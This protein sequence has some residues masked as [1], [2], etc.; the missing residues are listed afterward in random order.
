MAVDL[1]F[2]ESEIGLTGEKQEHFDIFIRTE[3]GEIINFPY[4]G[5]LASD[6]ME[7]QKKSR[8]QQTLQYVLAVARTQELDFTGDLVIEVENGKNIMRGKNIVFLLQDV[9]G[10]NGRKQYGNQ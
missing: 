7:S 5:W 10:G 9:L 2:T 3:L 1:F 6:L 4:L 8:Y